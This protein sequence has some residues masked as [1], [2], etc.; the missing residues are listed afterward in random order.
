LII[1]K[2]LIAIIFL[3][4]CLPS[5]LSF[6]DSPDQERIVGE[7]KHVINEIMTI[8]DQSIPEELLAKCKAIAIYPTVLNGGFLVGGRYGKGVVLK[9]D[10]KTGEWGP[11]SFSTI[12]GLSAGLQAGIQATD[13]V[14]IILNNKGLESLLTSKVTLGVDFALSVGPVGRTSELS[15]D[16]FLRSMILSYSRS[17]GLFAGAALNGSIVFPDNDANRSYY[18]KAVSAEDILLNGKAPLKPSSK[19]LSD[20]LNQYSLQWEKRQLLKRKNK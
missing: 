15:T 10:K 14:L 6:A 5:S 19:E 2:I 16:F 3:G 13:L 18:G 8:P 12:L 20:A 4:F 1:K 7:A 11:V 9:R 17:H